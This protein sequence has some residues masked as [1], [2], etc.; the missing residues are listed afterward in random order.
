MIFRPNLDSFDE[1][2]S[3]KERNLYYKIFAGYLLNEVVPEYTSRKE[4]FFDL[5]TSI[6]EDS[7]R[8][9]DTD[10]RLRDIIET[11]KVE[12][13]SVTFD[14]H[15]AQIFADDK[16][17][18]RGEMSDVLLLSDTCMVSVECKF[19]SNFSIDKD[20]LTVQ[21]RIKKFNGRFKRNPIQVLLL[22]KGKW[23]FSGKIKERINI[24]EL[25]CPIV[26]LF[27]EDIQNIIDDE[28][29]R[30]YLV[31]QLDRKFKFSNINT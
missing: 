20:I 22:K 24:G 18:D 12:D 26:V 30:D 14:Y 8:V 17:D 10:G 28:G 25:Y 19:G 13:M 6:H 29:V 9:F 2:E 21:N 7:D 16:R 31:K 23:S 11:I 1:L 5:I 27:W 3:Y 4:K 15:T